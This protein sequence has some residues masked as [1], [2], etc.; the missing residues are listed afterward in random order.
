MCKRLIGSS[1]T[2]LHR[3]C[4]II[5]KAHDIIRVSC[6]KYMFRMNK[7]SLLHTSKIKIFFYKKKIPMFSD[8]ILVLGTG[9]LL[10]LGIAFCKNDSIHDGSLVSICMAG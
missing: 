8:C 3:D 1:Y 6:I 7:S 10:I 5:E 2:G 9:P 4:V